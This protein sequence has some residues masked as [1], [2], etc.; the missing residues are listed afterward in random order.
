MFLTCT[1]DWS[2]IPADFYFIAEYLQLLLQVVFSFLVHPLVEIFRTE[3]LIL[4]S[5]FQHMPYRF[6]D[7]VSYCY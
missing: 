2:I 4:T 1:R 3:F 5:I 6:Q 7:R